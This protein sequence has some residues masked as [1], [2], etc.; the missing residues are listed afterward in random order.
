MNQTSISFAAFGDIHLGHRKNKTADIVKAIDHFFGHYTKDFDLDIIFLEGDV[1]DRLLDFPSDDVMEATIWI[2]NFLK[3]CERFKIKLRVLEGTPSHDWKQSSMF[4]TKMITNKFDV[5]FKY[6][7]S[8]S[9]EFIQDLGISVLYVPDKAATA[10][11]KIYEE[12]QEVLQA[13][14]LT[15]V[16]MACMH[17]MFKYQAPPGIRIPAHMESDYLSIVKH[18]ILI[19][20][21]HTASVYKRILAAGS[22]DRLTHGEEAAKGAVFGTISDV[23]EDTF[24]FIENKLA[25]KFITINIKHD[26]IESAIAAIEKKVTKLPT[27]SHVR[28]RGKKLN[29][30]MI[31]FEEVA[32]RFPTLY[33]TKITLEEEA[34]KAEAN[35]TEDQD[36]EQK[37]S[38]ISITRE[39]IVQL[40]LDGVRKRYGHIEHS[41]ER[42]EKEILSVL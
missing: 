18:F 8:I 20:H 37:Y 38:G 23:E 24:N 14:N 25:R 39:N 27:W 28:L 5:D 22:F 1:F 33:M 34:D 4:E 15:Q 7:T 17:G 11:E 9:V 6:V 19:G 30:V 31:A 40:L 10:P 2:H 26:D 41:V 29:P 42:V 36:P 13:N 12:V 35:Q 32:K 21:V 3:Y 16:D